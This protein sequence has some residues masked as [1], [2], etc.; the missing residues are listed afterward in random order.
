[1]KITVI[2]DADYAENCYLVEHENHAYIIDPGAAIEAVKSAVSN[3]PLPL[4]AIFL[5]HGHYDHTF[6]AG[7]LENI[8]IYAHVNEKMLLEDASINLSAYTGSPVTLDSVIY[9]SADRHDIDGFEFIHTPGHTAGC[10]VI[11]IGDSLFSGDTLFYDTIGRTDL[12]TG[13]PK[14]MQKSLKIFNGFDK[15]LMVYPG[16]GE[17]FLLGDAYKINYFLKR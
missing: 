7:S 12:P 6:S 10:V 5:T 13:D 8:P 16:H 1:M 2:T 4:K 17:P 3:T 9:F 11:K 14:A 15:G